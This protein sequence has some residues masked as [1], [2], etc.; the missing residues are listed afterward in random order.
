MSKR[1]RDGFD[2]EGPAMNRKSES[3]G[4]MG[5]ATLVGVAVVLAINVQG[6]FENRA[7]QKSLDERLGAMDLRLNQISAKVEQ[8]GARQP[9]P[10]Q[11]GPDP[12]RVYAIKTDGAPFK[13]PKDAPVV[14]AE[15][16]DFQ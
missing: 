4:W 2:K 12:N 11:R 8:V 5:L 14:I 9:A 10:A 6:V 15:F 3:T 13:G 1:P 7:T 16:S